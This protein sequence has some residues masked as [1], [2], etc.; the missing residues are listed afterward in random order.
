MEITKEKNKELCESFP[1]LLPRN[2]WTGDIPENF[3]FTYTELD[4]MPD[5]W[6]IAFGEQMC[7]EIRQELIK[8]NRLDKYRIVQIKE[9]FGELRWYDF[10]ATEAIY[11]IIK[12]YAKLSEKTCISCGDPAKHI[13]LDWISPFCEKCIKP[14]IDHGG[15]TMDIEVFYEEKR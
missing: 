12:K 8:A 9:K 2:R 3:D 10:G 6:R 1:F 11:N 15:K 14:Y 4:A 7:E 13:T 5:G